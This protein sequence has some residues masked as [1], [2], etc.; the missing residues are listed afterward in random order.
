M[1]CVRPCPTG[2]VDNFF[3]LARL[4]STSQQLGW[5]ELPPDAQRASTN[6]VRLS[7][8]ANEARPILPPIQQGNACERPT[9]AIVSDN[10]R[11]TA[12]GSENDVHHVIFDFG[13]SAFRFLE[14]QNIGLAPPGLDA[15]GCPHTMRLYSIASAR[16]GEKPNL[17]N[18][19]IAVKRVVGTNAHGIASNWICDL[20]SGEEVDVFGPFGST[21]LMPEDPEANILMI[22]TGTGVAPFRGFTHRRR[23]MW[24]NARGKLVLIYGARTPE[25]LPYYQPLQKYSQNELHRELVYSR[26]LEGEY[27]Y[28][29][30]RLRQRGRE[31]R[32]FLRQ[33]KSY[34]YIC[35]IRGLDTFVDDALTETPRPAE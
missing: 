1:K 21:F 34:I 22:C 11:I 3:E 30:D 27:G 10:Y 26:G 7:R 18:L 24:P 12:Q 15:S 23:R 25:E 20:R 28:V 9:R 31:V 32:W 6:S 19:A 8:A 2:A 5:L 14:G 35:G 29:Q 33:P 13:D 17:G 4:Y 16:D